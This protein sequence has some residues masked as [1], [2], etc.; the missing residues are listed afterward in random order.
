LV[1]TSQQNDIIQCLLASGCWIPADRK[2]SDDGE[3]APQVPRLKRLGQDFHIL[4]WSEDLYDLKVDGELCE[5]PHICSWNAVLAESRFYHPPPPRVRAHHVLPNPGVVPVPRTPDQTPPPGRPNRTP[6][7]IPTIPRYINAC[8]VRIIR[9]DSI[10][11]DFPIST[12]SRIEVSYLIQYLFLEMDDQRAKLLPMLPEEHRGRMEHLLGRY[13]RTVKADFQP[14]GIGTRLRKGRTLDL[15]RK[16]EK[17]SS[18]IPCGQTS[19]A[20]SQPVETDS[21]FER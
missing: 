12:N 11:Y 2:V 5:V 19:S 18:S 21:I 17:T 4:L 13:I 20:A 3:P 16:N 7:F 15:R 14:G 10:P 6:I 1:K 8:L 9:G